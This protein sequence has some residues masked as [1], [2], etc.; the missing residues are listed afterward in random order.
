MLSELALRTLY[1]SMFQCHL[2][3]TLLAWG[4][5]NKGT[6]DPIIK[7]QKNAIRL[8]SNA[9]YNSHTEPLFKKAEILRFEDLYKASQSEFMHAFLLDKLPASFDGIWFRNRR[10]EWEGYANFI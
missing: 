10:K 2:I 8:I 9:K 4:T 7:K 1:F 5:A 6:L 3:Y